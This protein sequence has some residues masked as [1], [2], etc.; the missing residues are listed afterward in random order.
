MLALEGDNAGNRVRRIWWSCY[1]PFFFLKKKLYSKADLSRVAIEE[2]SQQ[3]WKN[4]KMSAK[5]NLPQ[6]LCPYFQKD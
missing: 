5:N 2:T 1:L 3:P 4:E 6:Q